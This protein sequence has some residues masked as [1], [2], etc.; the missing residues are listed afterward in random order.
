MVVRLGRVRAVLL[1]TVFGRAVLLCRLLRVRFL[2]NPAGSWAFTR[3]GHLAAEPDCFIKE[4]LL[5][6]RP[7]YVGVILFRRD[8]A[9]NPCLLDYLRQRLW[10]ISS[11]FWTRL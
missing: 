7:W 4:G 6:L 10:V 3:V 11:P 8:L 1:A 9:A 2:A 5:G